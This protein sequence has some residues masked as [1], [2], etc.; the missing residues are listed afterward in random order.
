MP[1]TFSLTTFHVI[2]VIGCLNTQIYC[3][4]VYWATPLST[5]GRNELVHV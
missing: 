4:L 3:V 1:K 2:H 5:E